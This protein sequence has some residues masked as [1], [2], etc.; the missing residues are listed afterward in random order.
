MIHLFAD[1][2]SGSGLTIIVGGSPGLGGAATSPG[3]DGTSGASGK[4]IRVEM[5]SGVINVT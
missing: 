2:Y 4:V 1:D 5:Q 3:A